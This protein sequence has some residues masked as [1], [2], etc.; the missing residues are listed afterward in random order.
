MDHSIYFKF[1]LFFKLKFSLTL[2]A[3]VAP[4]DCLVIL[5]TVSEFNTTSIIPSSKPVDIHPYGDNLNSKLSFFHSYLCLLI[6]PKYII[7]YLPYPLNVSFVMLTCPVS[8]LNKSYI[9]R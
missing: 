8:N 7:P 6:P 4:P 1:R 3:A 9:C 5:A 2:K